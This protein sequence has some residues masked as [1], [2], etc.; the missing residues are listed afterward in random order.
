MQLKDLWS[1]TLETTKISIL[2]QSFDNSTKN[3]SLQKN[4]TKDAIA[5]ILFQP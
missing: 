1:E 5:F 2:L 4:L 3:N